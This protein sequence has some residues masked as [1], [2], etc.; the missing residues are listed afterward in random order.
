MARYAHHVAC[1]RDKHA[2]EHA[3]REKEKNGAEETS[4]ER[5]QKDSAIA[6]MIKALHHIKLQA[7]EN[8][9]KQRIK[10]YRDDE[11]RALEQDLLAQN[12]SSMWKNAS[13]LLVS[14]VSIFVNAYIN[15][16]IATSVI[17]TI[18]ELLPQ[19]RG[20]PGLVPL[21]VQD[22]LG[23]RASA[24]RIGLFL[25]T[26]D[27]NE[28]IQINKSGD[29][30]FR[31][32]NFKWPTSHNRSVST[33]K[34]MSSGF[35]LTDVDASFPAG[36]LSI[37]YGETGSG[38]S[39]MLAAMLGEAELLDGILE[40]PRATRGYPI[41]FVTQTTWLQDTT[42]KDNIMFGVGY[43]ASQYGSVLEA[44]SLIQDLDALQTVI[45]P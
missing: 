18:L 42:I 3:H 30:V 2:R 34:H 43:N 19:L 9:W 24:R 13:P 45:G 27:K 12:I 6:E 26:P 39:L 32:A 23:A 8:L 31:K 40:A 37:S 7:T 28:Y 35:T 15:G 17:F 38:K 10:K 5:D 11:L 25:R 36:R 1:H 16:Q 14:G 20:T 41:A 33:T 21:V 22:Y 4:K 44:C 29:I